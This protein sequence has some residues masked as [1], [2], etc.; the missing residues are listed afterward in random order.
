MQR[1]RFRLVGGPVALVGGP[2]AARVVAG[3]LL[4]FGTLFVTACGDAGDPVDEQTGLTGGWRTAGC[5]FSV[6]PQTFTIDGVTLPATPPQ[7]DAAIARIDRAGRGDFAT[8]YAGV[9][10]DQQR[11]RAVVYRVPSEAFD[12]VIRQQA[13]NACVIVRDAAHSAGD[14]AVWHDR[15]LADLAFWTSRGIRI[16]TIG[17]RHDGAGVEVGTRDLE[18]ARME[19]PAR[20]GARA[21]LIF[22]AEGPISPLTTAPSLPTV[23]PQGG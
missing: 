6:A 8:S 1:V 18:R 12:D 14:L 13:D 7:L 21:P 11:V 19:L 15:V 20:Y 5:E 2:A 17:A 22:I 16:V 10:V 3:A 23:A 4:A 9:E